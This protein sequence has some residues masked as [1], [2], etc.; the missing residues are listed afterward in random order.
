MA[1]STVYES[2]TCVQS[3]PGGMGALQQMYHD[4]QEPLQSAADSALPNPFASPAATGSG[5]GGG[6]APGTAAP[7]TSS[8]GSGEV[9]TPMP[10]PWGSRTPAG[11]INELRVELLVLFFSCR[12]LNHRR[13]S[14]LFTS[15]KSL[16]TASA[17]TGSGPATGES[18]SAAAG[19]EGEQQT[20]EGL[21]RQMIGNPQLVNEQLASP[22]RQS[23]L[24]YIQQNPQLMEQVR[25]PPANAPIESLCSGRSTARW[26]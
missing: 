2:H 12:L 22:W 23:M 14:L 9:N 17:G 3:M 21:L 5:G 10:N 7:A 1:C 26:T 25:C 20:P 15:S 6:S 24:Q 4:V 8:A 19:G 16:C 13:S 11:T 18:E